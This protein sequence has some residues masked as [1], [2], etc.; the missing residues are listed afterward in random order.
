[1]KVTA[2]TVIASDRDT[3]WRLSQTPDL[4]ARWDLRFSNIE[5]LA[6]RWDAPQ[7]FCYMTR[8]GFGLAVRGWGV[9]V[10]HANKTGSTLAF[11]STDPK[12]LIREGTGSWTYA[13]HGRGVRFSTVYDYTTRYGRFGRVLDFFFRPLM[14]WAT[15]WSFDRLRIWIE[16]GTRPELSFRL[17]LLKVLAR[18]ALAFTWMYEGL[19]PKLLVQ[20]AAE[21]ALVRDSHLAVGSPSQT[22]AALGAVEIAFGLW[23]ASGR[24][25]RAAAALSTIAVAGLTA[26]AGWVRPEAFADPLGGLSKNAGLLACGITVW[27]LSTCTPKASRAIPRR[28]CRPDRDARDGRSPFAAA[29][30]PRLDLLAP[31][32]RA[33][34]APA[35]E[36]RRYQGVMNRVWRAAG[37]RR[38]V[39]APFLWMGCRL[40]SLFPETGSAIPFEVINRLAPGRD[41]VLRMRLDRRFHFPGVERHFDAVV[42]YDHKSGVLHDEIGRGGRVLAELVPAVDGGA[43]VLRS[44]RQWITAFGGRLRIPL[45]RLLTADATIREWQESAAALGISVTIS[46]LLLGP[47]FGYEGTFHRVEAAEDSAG[48]SP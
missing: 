15:R 11:G 39:S 38:A 12:S 41:G 1:M 13:D 3:V 16:E 45:P 10:G 14:V 30:G 19:V 42:R 33:H 44:R 37:I 28:T 25:E 26:L 35:T 8:L 31:A 36:V 9:T 43:M 2:E 22:L 4:H 27:L 46:N 18:S 17:W 32:V 23:L 7:R 20:R 21:I 6:G 40:D 24:G 29:L 47:F 5:Y 48:A 34:F